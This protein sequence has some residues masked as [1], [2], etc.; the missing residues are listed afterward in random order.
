MI[1]LKMDYSKSYWFDDKHGLLLKLETTHGT[2]NVC[3]KI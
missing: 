2:P 3:N 1:P